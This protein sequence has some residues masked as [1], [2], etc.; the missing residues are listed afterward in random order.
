[1]RRPGRL[2]AK[3]ARRFLSGW[4]HDLRSLLDGQVL[5]ARLLQQGVRTPNPETLDQLYESLEQLAFESSMFIEAAYACVGEPNQPKPLELDDLMRRATA[6]LRDRVTLVPSN[7]VVDANEYAVARA[8]REMVLLLLRTRVAKRVKVSASLAGNSLAIAA[9][10]EGVRRKP[11]AEQLREALGDAFGALQVLTK[12]GVSVSDGGRGLKAVFGVGLRPES[13]AQVLVLTR[14]AALR[15]TVARACRGTGIGVAAW[16]SSLP[17]L[18]ALQ[19]VGSVDPL[20]ACVIDA[21]VTDDCIERLYQTLG[22]ASGRDR[23]LVVIDN[24]RKKPA[25]SAH[26]LNHVVL[27]SKVATALERLMRNATE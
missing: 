16:T 23:V 4:A 22:H 14:D 18:V 25:A 13:R 7:I 3:A 8:M 9:V 2:P 26:G 21:S 27:R 11:A 20:K 5:G 17:V 6:S 19:E 1:M 10:G 24:P 12:V 15:R